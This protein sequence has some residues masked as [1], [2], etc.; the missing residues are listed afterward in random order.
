M[1]CNMVIE[2][3]NKGVLMIEN[4]KFDLNWTII[5]W[6]YRLSDGFTLVLVP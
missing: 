1:I 4:R 3:E 2:F 6:L 5:E